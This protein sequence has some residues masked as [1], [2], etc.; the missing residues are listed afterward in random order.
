MD[1][2]PRPNVVIVVADCLR[3]DEFEREV[4]GSSFLTTLRREV[5]SFRHCVSVSNW[6]IPAHGSLLTGL[7]PQEHRLHRFGLNYLSRELPSIP[8]SLQNLGYATQ[9]LSANH[10]LRPDTGFANGFD[11][12]AFGIWG[13]TSL[14]VTAADRA[15]FDSLTGTEEDVVRQAIHEGDGT[16]PWKLGRVAAD[17]LPRF[18]WILNG[19]SRVYSGLVHG[20][21]TDDFRVAPWVESSLAR[22]LRAT[23]SRRPVFS[24]INLMDCHEPYLPATNQRADLF[25]RLRLSTSRQDVMSWAK[26]RWRP[27]RRQ[28]DTLIEL[29][30]Q[31]VRQ[32]GQRI[33]GIVS[34]LKE[35]GRWDNSIFIILSDH[36]QAF[37][38][39]N[40]MFHGGEL[41][42]PCVHVPLWVRYPQAEGGG[43]VV[44]SVASLI[45]I[46]PTIM[47]AVDRS[48]K[49][50][51][52]GVPLRELMDR[53]RANPVLSVADGITG[54]GVLQPPG[55][56]LRAN[57]QVAVYSGGYKLIYDS[58]S[59]RSRA[60]QWGEDPE[61]GRD[62]WQTHRDALR[63][64]RSLASRVGASMLETGRTE[65]SVSAADRLRSW[66][67][68]N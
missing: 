29:Y 55:I 1:G 50:Q 18:P 31:K 30:R 47:D 4:S 46:Y 36:G 33:E 68:L 10:S 24:L 49:C 34:L 57:P 48:W 13:E 37:G 66:G 65:P 51:L 5:V 21:V 63:S 9:L 15:P 2:A 16:G 20:G 28:L 39:H 64:P 3:E 14:R 32:V 45:D 59:M 60:F 54:F 19:V 7:Y 35:T 41:F 44:E 52:S 53:P 40:Q 17:I 11:Q 25:R 56:S 38:E 67:Y 22:F 43:T 23:P 6:T 8:T 12:V 27:S 61:E 26:G 62:L 42:E 58:W